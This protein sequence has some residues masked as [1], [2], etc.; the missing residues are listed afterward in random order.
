MKAFLRN[1]KRLWKKN[2]ELTLLAIPAAIVLF[3]ICYLPMFGIIIAFKD[4]NYSLG[5]LKSPWNGL[6]NFEFFFQSSNAWRI[7]RNTL[8]YNFSYIIVGTSI[9]VIFAICMNELSKGWIKLYQTIMF[10][11]YFISW[12]V[13]GYLMLSFLDTQYGLL[14]KAISYF[15]RNSHRVVQYQGILALHIDFYE[16]LEVRRL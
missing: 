13:V 14:N 12:I 2:R 16:S 8:L 11:P 9:S 3:L 1:E 15:W 7:T 10:I 6:K 5:I 4:Y